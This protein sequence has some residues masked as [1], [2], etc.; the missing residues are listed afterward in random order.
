MITN[1]FQPIQN[2]FRFPKRNIYEIVLPFFY[3]MKLFNVILITIKGDV[4]NGQVEIAIFDLISYVVRLFVNGLLIFISLRD[5]L[6]IDGDVAET[7]N[8]FF[9][10]VSVLSS[11]L[12]VGFVMVY[13]NK[14]WSILSNLFRFDVEMDSIGFKVDHQKQFWFQ[15][16]F[17]SSNVL[18]W[19]LLLVFIG[20][21]NG[22]GV[23]KFTLYI[24]SNC[25]YAFAMGTYIMFS[26]LI[27]HRLYSLNECIK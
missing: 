14:I 5:F 3:F 22:M 13:R 26:S 19:T 25:Q 1:R 6:K 18:Y 8:E 21:G 4:I 17:H 16:L 23:F 11:A 10:L 2:I 20:L 15:L 27:L 9:V 24:F 7:V 12:N